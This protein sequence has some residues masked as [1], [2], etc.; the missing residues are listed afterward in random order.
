MADMTP[1]DMMALTG[2]NDNGF[3]EGNGIIILILFFLMLGGGWGNNWGGNNAAMQGALTRAELADGFNMNEVQRN[4]SD[5][6]EGLCGLNSAILQNRY[7]MAI[8]NAN[9]G[10]QIA[11]NRYA[12]ALQAQTAQAQMASC[13]C[14]L[15]TAIHAEGEATRDM[16]QH[17]TIEDL[18]YQ[19]NQANT[20]IAN[21]VQTQNILNSLGRFYTNPSVNP[22]TVYNAGGCGCG[23]A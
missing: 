10:Q 14:D 4:Q 15:K 8:G 20:A 16:I 12:A 6:K 11:E 23:C 19:L 2:R 13:C 17:Q 22:Y 9:I 5:I 3:L 1:A 21:A 18:K 7:D